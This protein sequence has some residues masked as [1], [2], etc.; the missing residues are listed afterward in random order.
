MLQNGPV[1][2]VRNKRDSRSNSFRCLQRG[3]HPVK[4]SGTFSLIRA[5]ARV[6]AFF[7]FSFF[8]WGSY[9]FNS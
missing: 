2:R 3:A 1:I 8:A 5:R 9:P 4:C 6:K 7:S